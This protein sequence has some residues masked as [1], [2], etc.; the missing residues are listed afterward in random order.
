MMENL[1][2]LAKRIMI[3]TEK[4]EYS[5]FMVGTILDSEI[6]EREDVVRSEFKV[7]GGEPIKSEI[8]KELSKIIRRKNGKVISLNKPELNILVNTLFD[9]IELS[10]RSVFVKGMYVKNK[11][12][13]N[14]KKQRCKQCKSEGCKN[15]NFSGFMKLPSV[16]NE[17]QKYLKKKFNANEIKISWIGSEDQNSLVRYKG[18]PFFAEIS[19]PMKRKA[20]FREKKM[21]HGIIIKSAEILR[22]RPTIDHG[23]IMKAKVNFESNIK[24]EKRIKKI[25]KYFNDRDI[26]IY[27][28]NKRKYFTRK[29]ISIRMKKKEGN[30]I[31]VELVCEGGI[32]IK[33]LVSGENE[34]VEPNFRKILRI[35][36]SVDKEKPFDIHYVKFQESEKKLK[37]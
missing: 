22:K 10:S 15:C 32:N 8:T 31:T 19:S 26:S 3:K 9:E 21:N 13:I 30:R 37:T 7:K 24:D 29:I 18:R 14:Q 34:Q 28:M 33:K 1:S 27:S 12:G 17:I 16:E 4:F 36:C 6:I 23:F 11:R 2:K 35:K 20:L 5:S 25:E